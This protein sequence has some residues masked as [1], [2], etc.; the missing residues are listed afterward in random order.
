[1]VLCITV[2]WNNATFFCF[3]QNFI[4]SNNLNIQNYNALL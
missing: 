4:F 2:E 3:L 1:M